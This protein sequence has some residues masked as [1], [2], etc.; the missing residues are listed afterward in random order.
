FRY[1]FGTRRGDG[2]GCGDLPGF[3]PGSQGCEPFPCG[4]QPASVPQHSRWRRD[5]GTELAWQTRP[6][7][8][9]RNTCRNSRR[10][11]PRGCTCPGSVQPGGASRN[12]STSN[13][14]SSALRN[15]K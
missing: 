15:C 12:C 8:P 14:P 11:I 5:E 6:W 7:C 9:V 4:P 2:K 1:D 13:L 3:L 10:I